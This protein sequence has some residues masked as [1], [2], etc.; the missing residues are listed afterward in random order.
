M[1]HGWHEQ[2]RLGRASDHWRP[3][4]GLLDAAAAAGALGSGVGRGQLCRLVLWA[5]GV[6]GRTGAGQLA[7]PLD[8]LEPVQL[9]R[10]VQVRLSGMASLTVDSEGLHLWTSCHS[11]VHQALG[12]GG[13]SGWPSLPYP[14]T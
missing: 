9:G 10:H 1:P 4:G 12:W 6:P 3:E 5:S 14:M 11:A 2:A 13:S 7:Q 8:G